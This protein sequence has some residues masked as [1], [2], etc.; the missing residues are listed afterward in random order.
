[1]SNQR[2]MQ[3]GVSASKEDGNDGVWRQHKKE[4]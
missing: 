3:R 1:M 4:V 2:Y